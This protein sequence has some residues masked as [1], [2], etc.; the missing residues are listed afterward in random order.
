MSSVKNYACD[1][2]TGLCAT[3]ENK[4]IEKISLNKSTKVKL[5][6]YT[7][8]ICSACWAI[9]PE[10]RKFKLQY[11][12][13]FDLEYKM[14][15]LLPNWD[16]FADSSNGISGPEDVAQHWEEVAQH[17]GM[18]IDGDIWLED[19]LSSSFPPSIAYKAMQKQGE[20]IA[21]S[22]L[23]EMR[24]MVFLEKKNISKIEYML[25]AVERCRGDKNKFKLDNEDQ[26]TKDNFYAEI[27]EGRNM[28]VSGFPTFIFI[29]ENGSGFKIS[30][31]SG[32][33]QYV[34]ALEQAHGKKLEP[35]EINYSE[36]DLLKKYRYLATKEIS[37]I[38]NQDESETILNLKKLV[39]NST[40]EEV[41]QKFCLFWKYI[42]S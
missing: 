3:T 23:R 7:D 31:M 8:P 30:G 28:G 40:I 22:F 18:S 39:H 26:Q 34:A 36:L 42:G 16:G 14:G 10:L 20:P 19:P 12:K 41:R 24:I 37:V 15:G 1:I 33:A 27:Q 5:L 21:A 13:Y 29:G 9:E 35:Q 11:G 2:N 32:Y 6:Y 25:E 4:D 38:L 17:S